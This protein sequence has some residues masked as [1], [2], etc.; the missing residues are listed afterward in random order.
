ML[1]SVTRFKCFRHLRPSVRLAFSRCSHGTARASTAA[2]SDRPFHEL[3]C[4]RAARAWKQRDRKHMHCASIAAGCCSVKLK[5]VSRYFAWASD[6]HT[7]THT[8]RRVYSCSFAK[9][10]AQRELTVDCTSS[11][12]GVVFKSRS[13]CLLQLVC[14]ASCLAGLLGVK[15]TVFS[16]AFA[17]VS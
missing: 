15:S 2:R 11:R 14:A 5:N 7:H 4:L 9:S 8:W 17:R 13:T 3:P 16:A 12:D 10:S 1:P 6:R